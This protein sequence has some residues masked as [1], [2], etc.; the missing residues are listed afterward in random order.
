VCAA[1]TQGVAERW[2][3]ELGASLPAADRRGEPFRGT[4]F[5]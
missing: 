2:A 5:I 3:V 4:F 1:A